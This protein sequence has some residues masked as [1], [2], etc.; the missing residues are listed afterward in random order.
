M[1]KNSLF[2]AFLMMLPLAAQAQENQIDVSAQIRAR[3]EYRNGQGAL[4]TEGAKPAAFINERARIAIDFK[5]KDNLE[6][7]L[8][9]QHVGV[10]GDGAQIDK[11]SN[12][13]LNEAWAKFRP[14]KETFIQLGR[15]VLSY[16]DERILG[17]LDWHVSGRFHDA[18]KLGFENNRH[19]INVVL[20]YNQNAENASGTFYKSSET[21]TA[22]M[23][24]KAMEMLWYNY[25]DKAF[26]GSLLLMNINRQC[27]TEEAPETK[28]MQTIGTHLQYGTGNLKLTGSAYLQTGKTTGNQSV[29]A[30]MW[31]VTGTLKTSD[32]FSLNVGVDNLSGQKDNTDKCTAFN[33]LYGTHH[34]FT[35]AMDYF[36]FPGFKN[37]R[38]LWD[39]NLG[40]TVN[41][42]KKTSLKG[43]YHYFAVDKKLE[44]LEKTLGSEID[45]QLD[46]KVMKDVSLT[47]GYSMMFATKTMVAVK[48]GGNIGSWQDW[49]F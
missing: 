27:G 32:A 11:N 38:G 29:S 9:A 43:N 47:A 24:Y 15:Q 25:K 36:V 10:W 49:A 20:A 45:L 33:S 5:R 30:Y 23:D 42:S 46:W 28:N 7:R 13:V 48:G 44:G 34:K 18:L 35:G 26:S 16:D 2:A 19:K 22:S 4:R 40:A 3:G 12:F 31:S 21:P 39:L 37:N 8:A 17:G 14:S 1:N 6:L 41:L